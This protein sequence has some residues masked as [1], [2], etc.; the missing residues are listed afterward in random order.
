L[1]HTGRLIQFSQCGFFYRFNTAIEAARAGKAGKGFA[2]VADEIGKLAT[3]TSDNSK[4][5]ANEIFGINNDIQEGVQIVNTTKESTNSIIQM[6]G[7]INDQTHSVISLMEN[8]YTAMKDVE[9]QSMLIDDLSSE[10]AVSARQQTSSMNE[11]MGMI[12]R[13]SQTS[14]NL[15]NH[16][17]KILELTDSIN[18]KAKDLEFI[19]HDSMS[20]DMEHISNA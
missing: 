15:A 16:N 17:A 4:Q 2:V 3:A 10:I 8:Q 14:Q 11:A 18:Q 20:N 13:I 5:I 6:A 7:V 19:I 1:T 12:E 9:G